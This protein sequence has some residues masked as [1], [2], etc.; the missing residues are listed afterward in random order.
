MSRIS[1]LVM[2]NMPSHSRVVQGSIEIQY[3]ITSR[4]L[5]TDAKEQID[6]HSD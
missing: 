5:Q 3:Q 1:I 4:I 2:Y 6:T